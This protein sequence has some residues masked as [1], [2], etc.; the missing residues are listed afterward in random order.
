MP[1]THPDRKA[2]INELAVIDLALNGHPNRIAPLLT[3]TKEVIKKL[4]LRTRGV[5]GFTKTPRGGRGDFPN[6]HM[7]KF[8]LDDIEKNDK[9]EE[10]IEFLKKL[11]VT[12][13]NRLG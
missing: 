1:S 6:L 8:W 7:I 9:Y 4:R 2:R 5:G 11:H 12:L 13:A 3:M 10:D